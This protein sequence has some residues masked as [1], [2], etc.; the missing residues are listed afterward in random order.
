MSQDPGN[1]S[2]GGPLLVQ[3]LAGDAE[4]AGAAGVL[5]LVGFEGPAQQPGL[6]AGQR[7]AR[8]PFCHSPWL[9]DGAPDAA[10]TSY[11]HQSLALVTRRLL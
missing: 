6:D 2:Q 7:L 9:S 3:A 11:A 4:L 5:V 1:T 8:A 10:C